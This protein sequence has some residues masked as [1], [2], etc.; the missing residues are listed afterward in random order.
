MSKQ[1]KT[2]SEKRQKLAELL[3][4]FESDEFEIEQAMTRFAQAEKLADEIESELL[5]QQ[6]TITVLKERFASGER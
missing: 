1:P 6:N 5:K 3:A 2:I 4:W